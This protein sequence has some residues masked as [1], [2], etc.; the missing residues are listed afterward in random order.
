MYTIKRLEIAT[1]NPKNN[2]SKIVTFEKIVQQ[3]GAHKNVRNK[4]AGMTGV[5]MIQGL[6]KG[7]MVYVGWGSFKDLVQVNSI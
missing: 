4:K 7:N 6:E 3:G 1:N 2:I 5:R